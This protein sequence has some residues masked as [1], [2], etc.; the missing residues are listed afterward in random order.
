[1]CD[2]DIKLPVICVVGAHLKCF[3]CTIMVYCTAHESV[4][5][6]LAQLLCRKLLQLVLMPLL[7][8]TCVKNYTTC[9][10]FLHNFFS[11]VLKNYGSNITHLALVVWEAMGH[12][13]HEYGRGLTDH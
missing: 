11:S 9:V 7:P 3:F 8:A 6:W 1:M 5:P 13:A 2:G 10:G 4:V 12:C